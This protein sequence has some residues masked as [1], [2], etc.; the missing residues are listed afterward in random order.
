LFNSAGSGADKVSPGGRFEGV[1]EG[2][3]PSSGALGWVRFLGLGLW[4]AV[5][6]KKKKEA[7]GEAAHECGGCWG[8][9]VVK[10]RR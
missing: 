10:R 3:N 8:S 5:C 9:D 4:K 1:G 7:E 2:R 6:G